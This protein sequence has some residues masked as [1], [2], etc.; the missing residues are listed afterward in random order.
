[1]GI[2]A[3]ALQA[4]II[5]IQALYVKDPGTVTRLDEQGATRG[6]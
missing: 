5:K 3:H 2:P 6:Q 1:M 4:S